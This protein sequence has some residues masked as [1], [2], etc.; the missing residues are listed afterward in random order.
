MVED[1]IKAF[2]ER[3]FYPILHPFFSPI[4]AFLSGFY[5][6]Y[7][8]I[9]AIGFFVGTMIWVGLILPKSYVN[10]GCP[11]KAIWRDLRFW[12]VV[13]MLPHVLVYFYFY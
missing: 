13:S 1:A 8:T 2:C 7:A 5:Q 10:R 6:P 3:F 11:D 9:C 12:T 4:D